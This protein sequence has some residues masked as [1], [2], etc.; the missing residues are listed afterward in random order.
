MLARLQ[1][2][3]V[4]EYDH[5][6]PWHTEHRDGEAAPDVVAIV[7]IRVMN[8]VTPGFP[9]RLARLDHPRRLTLEFEEHLALQHVA[10]SRT[11]R[12]PMRRRTRA[13]WRIRDLHGHRVGVVG[14]E[15]GLYLLK[16]GH[17]VGPCGVICL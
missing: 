6:L 1:L 3:F 10:E 14:N 16:D 4:D 13:A 8:D 5:R 2:L 15:R 9:E 11:A 12:V 17:G 7:A